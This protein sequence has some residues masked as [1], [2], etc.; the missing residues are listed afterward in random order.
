[1]GAR[2]L[3][4]WDCV[5]LTP[6]GNV[7]SQVNSK[8]SLAISFGPTRCQRKQALMMVLQCTTNHH[9]STLQISV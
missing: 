4:I 3:S 8:S 5:S 1:M 7:P 9:T 6:K 2:L